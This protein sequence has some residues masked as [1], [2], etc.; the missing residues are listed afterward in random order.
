MPSA[1][2][3]AVPFGD[4]TVVVKFSVVVSTSLA[5]NSITLTPSS[6]IVCV[7]IKSIIGSL[8]CAN[9]VTLN[10]CDVVPPFPSSV[11]TVIV[12]SPIKPAVGVYSISL[13]LFTIAVPFEVVTDVVKLSPSISFA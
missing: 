9:T 2:I 12:E 8:F 13:L 11:I 4:T 3:T 1:L 5:L 10:V 6:L 7:E